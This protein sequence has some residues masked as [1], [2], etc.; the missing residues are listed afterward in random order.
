M[1]IHSVV[2]ITETNAISRPSEGSGPA[3]VP[4]DAVGLRW[5][6]ATHEPGQRLLARTSIRAA[7]FH[8]YTPMIAECAGPL[9]RT[10][11]CF[12]GYILVAWRDG[13]DW[14][15]ICRAK[16]VG[17]IIGMDR[18]RPTPIRTAVVEAIMAASDE[19]NRI[20]L[21]PRPFLHAA[22]VPLRVLAGPFLDASGTCIWA[23]PDR[24][25][26]LLNLLGAPRIVTLPAAD[27][28]AA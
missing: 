18:S 14:G 12:P 7:G 16:G 19:R 3:A 13:D 28:T 25:G 2:D 22:G 21:D 17:R 4:A 20:D 9:I 1:S 8:A 11:P 23:K 26:L 6:A 10:V 27:V 15:A 5:Y 24:V